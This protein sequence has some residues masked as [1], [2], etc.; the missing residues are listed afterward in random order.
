MAVRLSAGHALLF[1]N[2]FYASGTHLCQRLSEPQGIVQ[3]EGLSKLKKFIHLIGPRTRD[4]LA[5]ALTTMLPRTE[6]KCPDFMWLR[7]IALIPEV[8]HFVLRGFI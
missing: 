3:L 2:I 1:R 7:L 4:L 8:K 5:R 6:H